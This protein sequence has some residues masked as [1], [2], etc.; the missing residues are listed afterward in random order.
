MILPI[1][2]AGESFLL[3][4]NVFLSVYL[5]FHDLLVSSCV[6]GGYSVLR[7]DLFG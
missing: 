2:L 3:Q 4:G 5:V 1:W 6:M 7:G